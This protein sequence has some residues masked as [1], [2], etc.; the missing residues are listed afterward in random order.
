MQET[1]RQLI[2]FPKKG[3]H[4]IMNIITQ[5]TVIKIVAKYCSW[6][7]SGFIA[8]IIRERI[9]LIIR[10][11]LRLKAI[12]NSESL[13]CEPKFWVRGNEQCIVYGTSNFHVRHYLFISLYISSMYLDCKVGF[14]ANNPCCTV[15]FKNLWHHL[16]YKWMW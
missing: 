6:T 3:L 2:N 7:N 4:N 14:G 16:Q 12:D 10:E 13:A 1:F 11:R 5:Y 15:T 8:L 9:A